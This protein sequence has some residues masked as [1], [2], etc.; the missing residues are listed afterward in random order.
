MHS[1]LKKRNQFSV[2]SFARLGILMFY[3]VFLRKEANFWKHSSVKISWCILPKIRDQFSE[4]HT[5]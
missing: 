5:C 3:D 4:A 2:A 1:R